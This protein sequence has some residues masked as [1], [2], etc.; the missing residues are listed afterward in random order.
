MKVTNISTVSMAEN[1]LW[2]KLPF[3]S[4]SSNFFVE[5]FYVVK[6]IH[7]MIHSFKEHFSA[8]YSPGAKATKLNRTCLLLS[9][10]QQ[11]GK[12][13]WTWQQILIIKCDEDVS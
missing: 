4:F 3:P 8:F 6:N 13:R 11:Y 5:S 10:R 7:D 2:P 12:H 9:W 1:I